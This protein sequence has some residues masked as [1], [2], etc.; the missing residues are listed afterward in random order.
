MADQTL[1]VIN[2]K[3]CILCGMCVDVCPE[4]VLA[5]EAGELLI[6]HPD[7]CTLCAEC[8][9]VCPEKAVACYYQIS[10]AENEVQ[11]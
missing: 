8:E 4:G 1:P 9:G 2:H 3:K 10:W 6:A 11:Q 7:R 5:L